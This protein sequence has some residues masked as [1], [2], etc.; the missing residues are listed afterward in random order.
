MP[1]LFLPRMVN[2]VFG[3]PA[4]LVRLRWERRSF[5][6]DLGD[7]TAVPPADLMKVTDVFVSHTHVDH[8]IGFDHLLRVT[9][10]RNR[11]IRLFGPPGIIANVEGKLC[12]YTWNLV[13]GYPLAFEVHEVGPDEIT[14]ARFPCGSR[15]E[16]I[17]HAPPSPFLGVLVE[18]PL[19]VVKA[20]HLDH[21][22]PC[23]GFSA[24]EADR[25][26][27]DPVA[28]ARLGLLPGPWLTTLKR[29]IR[30]GAPDGSPVL[31][32]CGPGG[33][34]RVREIPLGDLKEK[35][36]RVTPGQKLVYVTD[37]LYSEQNRK[38]IV[39]LAQGA[40]LFFCEAAYLEQD[41]H[42]AAERY[43]L[44]ARQAGLLARE[45]KAKELVLFHFSPR[46]QD[47]PEDLYREA[48]EAFGGSVR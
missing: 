18:E 9:L 47:H 26:N 4:L 28:I 17:D 42:R 37:V 48:V 29:L 21:R 5:L 27:V 23:L 7:L 31:A 43:H 8:F 41:R 2:G 22:I 20:A 44:T 11:L 38:Q 16:R 39:G 33:A 14:V 12:G 45:A 34:E 24:L 15:F 6:M 19:V 36:V 1:T 35:I 13:D 40:D 3:D 25:L 10:G 30:V 46:Y 32:T